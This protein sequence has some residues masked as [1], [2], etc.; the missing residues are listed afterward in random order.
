MKTSLK[1]WRSRP[2]NASKTEGNDPAFQPQK[3]AGSTPHQD[4]RIRKL[5]MAS[6]AST[7]VR[8]QE[9]LFDQIMF[10]SVTSYWEIK[11]LVEVVDQPP[12]WSTAQRFH[13][14]ESENCTIRH[15][16][17]DNEVLIKFELIHY[18]TKSSKWFKS[19][20]VIALTTPCWPAQ[21]VL[22]C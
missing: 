7:T 16:M 4:N 18:S 17:R 3:V 22:S 1:L 14:V 2:L 11:V 21:V 15:D 9:K 8:F 10:A 12:I 6:K 13:G 5:F 20:H 19:H